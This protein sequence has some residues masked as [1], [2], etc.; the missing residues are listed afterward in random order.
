MPWILW[1]A[2]AAAGQTG[3]AACYMLP[4]GLAG[5]GTVGQVV[6]FLLDSYAFPTTDPGVTGAVW[7]NN[8]TAAISKGATGP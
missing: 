8:L 2:T 5:V 3:P 7:S 1:G 4:P 6:A